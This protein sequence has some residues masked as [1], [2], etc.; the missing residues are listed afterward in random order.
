MKSPRFG[1]HRLQ[2][3]AFRRKLTILS[4]LAVTILGVAWWRASAQPTKPLATLMPGS[5]LLY[6]EASDFSRLLN[7]WNGSKVKADWLKSDN[8]EVFS[9]SNLFSKLSGLLDEYS[10][11]AGFA[12]D[13]NSVIQIAGNESALA[14]YEIRELQFLY[15]TRVEESKLGQAALWEMRSKF[16]A[17]QSAGIT[18]YVHVASGRTVAFAFTQGYLF[19]GTRDDLVA[20]ALALLAGGHEPSVGSERWYQGATNAATAHGELRLV[21]NLESLVKSVYFR[22]YW[23]QRNVSEMKQFSAGIADLTR[24]PQKIVEDRV[25]LRTNDAGASQPPEAARQA[26]TTLIPLAPATAGLYKAWA[27]P[28]ADFIASLIERKLLAPQAKA[29]VNQRYAP[30]ASSTGEAAGTEADLETR[31]DEPPLPAD[32]SGK[33]E[34]APLDSLLEK[35]QPQALLQVQSAVQIKN[36]FIGTPSLLAIAAGSDWDRNAIHAALTAAVETLWTTSSLGAQWTSGTAGSH[37]I[38]RLDGLAPLMMAVR[39]RVLLISNDAELL[40]AA[41]DAPAA[42]ASASQITYSAVFRHGRERGN[43]VHLMNALDFARPSPESQNKVEGSREP[44]FF[45][46]NIASLSDVLSFVNGVS[47][48]ASD[49]GNAVVERVV[50]DLSK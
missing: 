47:V 20:Q 49:R 12:P 19:V 10:T 11:A 3:V 13:L 36:G 26:L 18:F 15:V 34:M 1:W 9:R 2:P 14:L 27:A 45:S 37:T 35:A 38:D 50:Y 4:A 30:E 43:F 25:L 6:L 48:T 22:S 23:V 31:I 32:S 42:P 33:L 40:A 29:Q 7:E 17:R 41:L 39:G 16:E 8:H 44:T 5:A 46:G 24:D 28:P 21:L